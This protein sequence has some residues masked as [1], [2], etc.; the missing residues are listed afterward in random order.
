MKKNAECGTRRRPIGRDYA[1]AKDAE[2]GMAVPQNLN[3]KSQIA[4]IKRFDKL[5]TLS[6]VEG[7]I[8]MTEIQN[9][10]P[11]VIGHWILHPICWNNF[12]TVH[13]REKSGWFDPGFPGGYL[14][15]N[16]PGDQG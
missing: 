8:T 6:Q 13:C 12:K 5:T 3:N 1:A 7:Q 9:P 10:K 11:L 15:V 2:C 14:G 4:N 16:A